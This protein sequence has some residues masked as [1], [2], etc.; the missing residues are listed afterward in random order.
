MAIFQETPVVLGEASTMSGF[1]PSPNKTTIL[2]GHG[3][4]M[5]TTGD[6][7][8]IGTDNAAAVAPPGGT[9]TYLA[10]GGGTA[11]MAWVN[12]QVYGLD[13]GGT[14]WYLWNPS[15]QSWTSEPNP[16]ASSATP[17]YVAPSHGTDL[18]DLNGLTWTINSSGV[19]LANGV[20][21]GTT[22]N[23]IML[24]MPS[25]GVLWYM[26]SSYAWHYWNLTTWVASNTAP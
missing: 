21:L 12:N 10:D 18:I 1:T 17:G 3:S 5:D 4:I 26:N 9:L 20:A 8:I 19:V 22:S 23:A 15:A 6:V 16:L 7:Y 25:T 11:E 2:P 14:G 24:A 13:Q